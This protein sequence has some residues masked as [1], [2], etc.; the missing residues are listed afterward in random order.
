MSL[1]IYNLRKLLKIFR[2]K[3][4]HVR[5]LLPQVAVY[6]GILFLSVL[7]CPSLAAADDDDDPPYEEISVY[8][9]LL[10]IPGQELPALYSKENLYISV[11]DLFT[12]LHIMCKPSTDLKSVEGFFINQNDH[13]QIDKANNRVTFKNIVYP[14][15]AGDLIKNSTSLYLK[16]SWFNKVFGLNCVF[17]FRSLSVTLKTQLDLPVIRE[18]RLEY[19]RNNIN[20][21]KQEVKADSIIPRST[22]LIN[23][24][25]V[26]W[27]VISSQQ[28][29]GHGY[30]RI[31]VQAGA[32]LAGGETTLNLTQQ[33]DQQFSERQQYYRWRYV[34]N[35]N[36][37][38]RQFIAGKIALQ[39]VS[40]IYVPIIGVQ[41]TNTPTIYRKSFA[42]YTISDFT[43]AGWIVE[44]YVNN[45]L[46]N[47][48]RA[49]A[50]GFFTLKVP[51][52]YGGSD[53]QLRFY[54][55]YGEVQTRSQYLAVPYNFLPPKELEYTF[56][57][58]IL[59]DGRQSRFSRLY[60]NYG[61]SQYITVGGGVEYLSNVNPHNAMPFVSTSFRALNNLLLSFDY[62]YAVRSRTILSYRLPHDMLFELNYTKYNPGQTAISYNYLEERKAS[63]SFPFRAKYLSGYSRL[64]FNQIILPGGRQTT[65][66][67]VL[68]ATSGA[69]STNFTTN[70]VVFGQSYSNI[71]SNL[72]LSFRLFNRF[73]LKP[74]VQYLYRTGSISE[75]KCNLDK[76]ILHNSY[77][78]LSYQN[79]LNYGISSFNLGLRLDLSFARAAFSARQSN[80][81]TILTES[82]Q[83]SLLFDRRASSI[84]ANNRSSV[85]MGGLI[86]YTYL[87]LNS[88]NRRDKNEPKIKGLKLKINGARSQ[89]IDRDSSIRV[90]DLMPYTNYYLELDRNSFD[91]IGWQIK[92]AV[93]KVTA[94]PNNLKTIEVPVSVLAEASGT[95]NLSHAGSTEG[96]GRILV[97]FYNQQGRLVAK[98]QTEPDGYFSYLGLLPGKYRAEVDSVQL[99]NLK[100]RCL[101]PMLF[102]VLPKL[103]GDVVSGL[104]LDLYSD[105]KEQNPVSNHITKAIPKVQAIR[106]TNKGIT[107]KIHLKKVHL[108]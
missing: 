25:A 31:N 54:G 89:N 6:T 106:K 72:A 42:D 55:T 68:S 13:Y 103:E 64:T 40:S 32:M 17:N 48:V 22:S 82:F 58:G 26:D 98:T 80:Q 29:E 83:G 100:M 86:V 49:D 66:E 102:K 90:Y 79:N 45:M 19:L 75:I 10:N 94:E 24:G 38:I 78:N 50:S 81:T 76:Q 108:P 21:L 2:L 69:I 27:S 5:G 96:I 91:N 56:S 95:V 101:K 4:L 20:R 87:D 70:A 73:T 63:F 107:T 28:N 99:K 47:Y 46:V 65:G 34:N 37:L 97:N 7:F 35:E 51:L 85:G 93:I 8:F 52:I 33:T 57:A 14:L 44:L 30:S 71:Y 84:K 43:H 59:E 1:F 15:K 39:S 88:N 16:T 9:N 74:Q 77:L 18:K 41:F 67:Y 60:L 105:E 36:Y 62:T 11:T 23:F 12:Y 61:L 104:K 53:V 92:N 3:N